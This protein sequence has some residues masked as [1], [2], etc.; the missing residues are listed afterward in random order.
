MLRI[1][2]MPM[3]MRYLTHIESFEVLEIEKVIYRVYFII[4][5]I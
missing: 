2:F 4:R 3:F 5:Q 1:L